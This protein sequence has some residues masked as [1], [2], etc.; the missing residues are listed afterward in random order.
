MDQQSNVPS[1]P[2]PPTEPERNWFLRHE[3]LYS[4]IGILLLVVIVGTTYWWKAI[5]QTNQTNSLV[6]QVPLEE[7]KNWKTYINTLEGVEFRIPKDWIASEDLG[8]AIWSYES[9]KTSEPN[10]YHMFYGPK[11]VSDKKTAVPGFTNPNGL[12]F[13]YVNYKATEYY[14][15]E[16]SGRYFYAEVGGGSL[17][18]LQQIL[19][20]I[21]FLDDKTAIDTSAWKTY[22]DSKKLD[23]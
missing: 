11:P 10:Y 1:T 14:V 6:R 13:E 15:T 20:T 23:I 21:K 18:R 7:T 5:K 22:K 16:Q 3:V 8:I 4:V 19:S 2:T 9:V 12:K 17:E